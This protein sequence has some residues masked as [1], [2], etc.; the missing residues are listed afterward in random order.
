MLLF[1]DC[2]AD[3]V[4]FTT[5]SRPDRTSGPCAVCGSSAAV[6]GTGSWIIAVAAFLLG[7]VLTAVAMLV[8]FRYA[9]RSSFVSLCSIESLLLE[10]VFKSS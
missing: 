7:V 1:I 3:T 8:V 2:H 4:V 9:C 6:L 10:D 5:T